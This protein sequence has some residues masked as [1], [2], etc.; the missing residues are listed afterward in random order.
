M[1]HFSTS[2]VSPY[3]YKDI[4][5]GA[6]TMALEPQKQLIPWAKWTPWYAAEE[7]A[8]FSMD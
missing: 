5:I 8:V 6:S 3:D 2:S 4:W 1:Y 7:E